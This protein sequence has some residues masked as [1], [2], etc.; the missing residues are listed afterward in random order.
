MT[1]REVGVNTEDPGPPS[2]M[3]VRVSVIGGGDA[4]PAELREAEAL[5]KYL[6]RRRAIIITGGLGGVMEA[7]SRGCRKGG[8]TTVGFLP[9]SDPSEANP[10]VEI[11]LAT[12]MGEA[13]NVLVVRGGDV[14]VAVGGG[15]GTLSEI[16][17]ARKMG[18]EVGVVGEPMCD[19]SLP[20]F[21][22]GEEGARWALG[23]VEPSGSEGFQKERLNPADPL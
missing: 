11:P 16:A 22:S 14:V 3:P 2:A 19:L 4:S 18:R 6:G 20:C 7:A 12:G 23:L 13:R 21:K 9:G 5:G 10:W 17:L 15:W 8:G 1:S